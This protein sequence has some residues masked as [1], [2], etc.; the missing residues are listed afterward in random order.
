MNLSLVYIIS[1]LFLYIYF[2]FHFVFRIGL[3]SPVVSNWRGDCYSAESRNSFGHSETTF[4]A[5]LTIYLVINC[6]Y[7]VQSIPIRV[8]IWVLS[9]P[10]SYLSSI[11]KI[12]A[13]PD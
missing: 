11:S 4:E 3:S 5:D 13:G 2:I 7:N 10:M 6:Q 8:V 12:Q 9:E 1:N